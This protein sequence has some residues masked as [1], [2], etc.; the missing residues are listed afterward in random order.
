[1]FIFFCIGME[2]GS[3]NFYSDLSCSSV[4]VVGNSFRNRLENCIIA[5]AVLIEPFSERHVP[6]IRICVNIDRV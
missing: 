4:P 6:V 1:M 5:D 2:I 3:G